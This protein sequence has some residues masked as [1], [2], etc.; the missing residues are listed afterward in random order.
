M[1]TVLRFLAVVL[2]IAVIMP[3][4][5]YAADGYSMILTYTKE[6]I[7]FSDLEINIYRIADVNYDKLS[8][9][10]TYPVEVKGITSQ[11]EWAS[12]AVTLR[13]YITAD[14]VE[15]YMTAKTDSQGNAVFDGIGEGLYLVAGVRSERD[16]RI[17]S[18]YDFM[19]F[20]T[21][22]VT[23]IPKAGISEPSDEEKSYSILKLWKNDD[24]DSRP[25]SVTV[26]ILKDGVLYETVILDRI[27][28]WSYSFKCD[29]DSV[30]SVAERNVPEGYYVTLSEKEAVFVITNTLYDTDR[31]DTT[32]DDDTSADT[33]S[34]TVSPGADAPQTGDTFPMKRYVTMLCV[35]G[36]LLVI[37][38]FGMRRKED[39]KGR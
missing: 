7:I 35:S 13:S 5:A 37:L 39:E 18:F 19:I 28:D 17:F 3:L 26:D 23:A 25:N 15:P 31:N 9:Y 30:L 11:A 29:A 36:M 4:S 27:N 10:D 33:G 16:G 2:C 22:D 32:S 24:P 8:P 14:S 12:V 20:V 1:K 6:N 38:G 34:N 21:E